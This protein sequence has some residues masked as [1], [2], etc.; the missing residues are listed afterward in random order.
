GE[1]VLK[2]HAFGNRLAKLAPDAHR[3]PEHIVETGTGGMF[4]HFRPAVDGDL[5]QLFAAR[6]IVE[7]LIG[8]DRELRADRLAAEI[9]DNVGKGLEP[10]DI[11]AAHV[12]IRMTEMIEA[13]IG[14][15]HARSDA[16]A[17]AL[18]GLVHVAGEAADGRSLPARIDKFMRKL[19]VTQA[20]VAGNRF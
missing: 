17:G 15:G 12:R 14:A 2:L 20:Q 7:I 6:R 16:N 19:E 8:E 11:I 9:A 4:G 18:Q 10:V 3:L 5:D 1:T 13:T